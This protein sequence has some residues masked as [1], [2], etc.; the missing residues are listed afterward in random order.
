MN[1]NV[2]KLQLV[3]RCDLPDFLNVER[4]EPCTT[5]NQNALGGLARRQLVLVVLPDRKGIGL[6]FHAFFFIPKLYVLEHQVDGVF[7][8]LVIFPCLRCVYHGKERDEIPLPLVTVI[9]DIRHI[10]CEQKPF[11]LYPEILP[12]LCPLAFRVGNQGVYKFQNVLLRPDID[13]RIVMQGL[14]KVNRIKNLQLIRDTQRFSCFLI[15]HP[16]LPVF[17]VPFVLLLFLVL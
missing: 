14:V 9:H 17:P 16:V 8:F 1:P 15:Q 12:A 4:S 11:R 6:C 13:E 10:S 3:I 2:P 7:K 5:R